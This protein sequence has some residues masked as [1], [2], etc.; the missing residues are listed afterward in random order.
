M[1]ETQ[2]QLFNTVLEVLD[3]PSPT[4]KE[5]ELSHYIEK[6]YFSSNYQNKS[7]IKYR[8]LRAGNSF[9]ATSKYHS[10][11]LDKPHLALVG[12]LDVVP[13][14]FKPYRK[15]GRIYG[16]GA[17]DMQASL[18]VFL[19]LLKNFDLLKSRYQ[20]S[21]IFY[22]KE[23][24]TFLKDNGL[25]DL[26]KKFP[27]WFKSVDLALVGEPTDNTV[28]I[29]CC[30]SI[31][32]R[33]SI[34]GQ[35]CHS[36]RPWQGVNALYEA[37]PF[38][39]NMSRLRPRPYKIGG[40]TF[41]DVWQVT[42]GSTGK[43]KTTT[44]PGLWEGN[45][46]FRFAPLEKRK[47]RSGVIAE[48]K[49]FMGKVGLN[50]KQYQIYSYSPLGQIVETPLYR[51]AVDYLTKKGMI[52]EAKQAWTDVAQLGS[53]GIPAFNCGPGLSAQCHTPGEYALEKYILR[54][55][56]ILMGLLQ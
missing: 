24:E 32:A 45:I 13:H 9:I 8:L 4:F 40:V 17:S 37:L 23:E 1:S 11:H 3:I 41:H 21:F 38:L 52:V 44:L 25:Y 46:N 7:L 15:R 19:Y 28:Q 29:G 2:E 49:V 5:K 6:H 31:H 22:A 30:G 12:H 16:A 39:N 18:G 42:V 34:S 33:V 27:A 10:Q 26:I 54:Y 56:K 55:T 48:F 35:A 20:T 53:I 14:Y 51:K 47:K 36:A 50:P 43:G